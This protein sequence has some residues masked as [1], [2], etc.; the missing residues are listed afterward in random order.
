MTDISDSFPHRLAPKTASRLAFTLTELTKPTIKESN[1]NKS[2][3]NF[4]TKKRSTALIPATCAALAVCAF[5]LGSVANAQSTPMLQNITTGETVFNDDFESYT[6]PGAGALPVPLTANAEVGSW[7]GG[8]LF[9]SAFYEDGIANEARSASGTVAAQ[10]GTNYLMMSGTA[11][12]STAAGRAFTGNGDASKSLSG[13]TIEANIA[14]NLTTGS[15]RGFI[16][17][18]DGGTLMQAFSLN[19]VNAAHTSYTLA[20]FDGSV[21]AGF[22][23]TSLAFAPDVWNTLTV[24]YVN[25]STTM[26]VSINGGTSI[27]LAG[28]G[29]LTGRTMNGVYFNQTTDSATGTTVYFDAVAVPEPSSSALLLGIGAIMMIFRRKIRR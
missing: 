2:K 10:Q 5:S 4:S 12:G 20:G 21:P 11:T 1:M 26:D 29:D 13:N 18:Y 25:G 14:F 3:T 9:L 17:L 28:Y 27:T 7:A 22:L 23:Q 8:T 6:V 16:Y 19:G 24:S 15:N